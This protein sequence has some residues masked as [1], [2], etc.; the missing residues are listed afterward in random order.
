MLPAESDL[1]DAARCGDRR[2]FERLYRRHVGRVYATCLRLSGDPVAAEE[3][4]QETFI[5]AWRRLDSYRAAAPFAAWLRRLTINV[6]LSD[7]RSHM[8]RLARVRPVAELEGTARSWQPGTS[9]D[10]ERAVAA[11]PPKA[12]HVFVLRNIEGLSHREIAQLTGTSEGTS[13]A[14]LHRARR[15]LQEALS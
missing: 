12:R 8:R 5:R 14:Q 4:T 10:L 3:L 11:L 6:A 2:A 7:K 13:K 15:L 9:L 1:I